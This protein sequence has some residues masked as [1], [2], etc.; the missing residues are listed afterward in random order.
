MKGSSKVLP[1]WRL[2]LCSK[3]YVAWLDTCLWDNNQIVYYKWLFRPC[4]SLIKKNSEKHIKW[5]FSILTINLDFVQKRSHCVGKYVLKGTFSVTSM[6]SREL[7]G[8]VQDRMVTCLVACARWPFGMTHLSVVCKLFH[9]YLICIF[10]FSLLVENTKHRPRR[11]SQRK[12]FTKLWR[13]SCAGG[14]GLPPSIAFGGVFP[15]STA[16]FPRWKLHKKPK[17]YPQNL[18][19]NTKKLWISMK[20]IPFPKNCNIGKQSL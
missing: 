18:S 10:N 8:L 3:A 13:F 4:F 19:H 5:N 17:F 16:A 2:D 15:E 6:W 20:I 11:P 1:D 12:K 14:G 9:A 7:G